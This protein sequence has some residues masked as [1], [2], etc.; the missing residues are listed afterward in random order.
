[1]SKPGKLESVIMRAWRDKGYAERLRKNPRNVLREDG[2]ELPEGIEVIVLQDDDKRRHLVIP[3][4]PMKLPD[5]ED[6]LYQLLT[7]LGATKVDGSCL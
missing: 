7:S 1:M 6:E 2:I 5:D 4:A 3:H